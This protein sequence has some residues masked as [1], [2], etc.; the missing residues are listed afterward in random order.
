M[1]LIGRFIIQVQYR[2]GEMYTVEL[3]L[4][5]N[6]VRVIISPRTKVKYTLGI[7]RRLPPMWELLQPITLCMI[8]E[9]SSQRIFI[10][11]NTAGSEWVQLFFRG[12]CLETIRS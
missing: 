8:I 1:G 9:C 7:I 4:V 12:L 6:I 2:D 10:L 5:P 3:K 11:V